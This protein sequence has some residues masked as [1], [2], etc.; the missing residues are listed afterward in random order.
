MAT[1]NNAFKEVEKLLQNI[2][3]KIE[4]LIAAGKGASADAQE[5]IQ[6]RVEELKKKREEL[7]NDF[8]QKKS[9]GMSLYF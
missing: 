5:E 4:E 8:Y 9:K 7:E 1:Q 2:G 6:K 3:E